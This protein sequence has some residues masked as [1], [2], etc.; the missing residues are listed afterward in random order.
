MTKSPIPVLQLGYDVAGFLALLVLFHPGSSVKPSD[1]ESVLS[2]SVSM[3]KA[4]VSPWL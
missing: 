2:G 4:G 3:L 1:M